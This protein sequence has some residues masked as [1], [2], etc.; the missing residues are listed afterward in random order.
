MESSNQNKSPCS[1]GASYD[2]RSLLLL[3]AMHESIQCRERALHLIKKRCRDPELR[4]EVVLNGDWFDWVNSPKAKAGEVGGG[5]GY[6]LGFKLYW[7]PL[8]IMPFG[9]FHLFRVIISLPLLF[10]SL[11]VAALC[12]RQKLKQVEANDTILDICRR[13][14]VRHGLYSDDEDE[15]AAD[16]AGEE[17]EEEEE[18]P[19]RPRRWDDPPPPKAPQTSAKQ[20]FEEYSKKTR[21]RDEFEKWILSVGGVARNIPK[22]ND[23]IKV[24]IEGP[25][26]SAASDRKI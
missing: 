3:A 12:E 25:S 21:R 8:V 15:E 7:S 23:P 26:L 16:D 20:R 5:A 24:T 13:Y 14:Q 18:E 9:P 6:W 2:I 22:K 11:F 4:I 10:F 19:P 17:E 1:P